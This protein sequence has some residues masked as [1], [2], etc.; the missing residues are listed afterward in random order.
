MKKVKKL[1][2]S[3]LVASVIVS[4][5]PATPNATDISAV[6]AHSGRTDSSGGHHDYSNASGL[7][8][9]HYHCG[10]YPAHLH[11]GG[12]CPYSNSG[13]SGA[14]NSSSSGSPTSNSS[15][16]LKMN[17]T[18]LTVGEGKIFRLKLNI[19]SS[20]ASWRSSNRKVASLPDKGVVRTKRAGK[21]TISAKYKG[22]TVK[23]KLIVKRV[24]K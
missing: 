19:A 12:V 1:L 17:R 22:Q 9:Y 21:T 11:P 2:T 4:T 7:G 14:N 16:K 10:G 3:I 8:S 24:S 20:K 5:A 13:S 23:C 15:F 6:E 18:S